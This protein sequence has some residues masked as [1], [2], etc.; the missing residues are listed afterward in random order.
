MHHTQ[1]RQQHEISR[2]PRQVFD[3]PRRESRPQRARGQTPNYDG[4]DKAKRE[5]RQHKIE[6]RL[7]GQIEA[8]ISLYSPPYSPEQGDAR[9]AERPSFRTRAHRSAQGGMLP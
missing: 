7:R 4:K 8:I 9:M 6:R 5:Q 2:I 3:D 1:N